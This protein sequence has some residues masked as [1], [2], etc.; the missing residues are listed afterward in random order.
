MDRLP[1]G[2]VTFLFTDI[3]GSTQLIEEHPDAMREALGRH[4][5]L[6]QGVF[7]AHRGRVF[8]V[9]GDAFCAVFEGAGDALA[10]AL[11]A[12][13]ALYREGWGALGALRVR[14]G[15]HTGEAEVHDGEYASSLTLVRAQRV[16]S[17]GHGGQTLLSTAAAQRVGTELP[18]GTTLRDLGP[19]KLRGLTEAENIYQLIAADLPAEFA[20]LRVEDTG[21]A[22]TASLQQ[23]VRGRL[24]GR[25][26]ELQQLKLHWD[27]ALQ[28]RSH[29]VLLSGEP[30][31]G[32]TRLAQ[33][34]IAHARHSGA[35]ILRGGCYE[36]E[37]TTPY[38]PFVEAFRD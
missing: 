27:Q 8:K 19:H 34:L 21:T 2:V 3:E 11:D 36:Y 29:L 28:A 7:A 17:A 16:T 22:S 31:V 33:D 38:L 32:K 6:L 24:I 10:A 25:A 30:G 37:A 26:A 23:L 12:Q 9:I 18:T 20:P 14:M 1:T 5:A 35:T 15:L 13:R 4:H